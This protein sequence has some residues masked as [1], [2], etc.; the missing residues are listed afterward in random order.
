[1]SGELKRIEETKHEAYRDYFKCPFCDGEHWI[2]SWALK[3]TECTI[4]GAEY[5]IYLDLNATPNEKEERK[6]Q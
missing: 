3:N 1:M 6:Q 5:E 2:S 4:C